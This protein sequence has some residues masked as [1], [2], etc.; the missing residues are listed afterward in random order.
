M[1]HPSRVPI[2]MPFLDFGPSP[3]QLADLIC[4]SYD[5]PDFAQR[6]I[7][8]F[9]GNSN[10]HVERAV[11][12]WATVGALTSGERLGDLR[13]R[14]IRGNC[15][16]TVRRLIGITQ[17]EQE[18][19]AMHAVRRVRKGVKY[20]FIGDAR[21][22]VILLARLWHMPRL[23]RFIERALPDKWFKEDFCSEGGI[24]DLVSA[25]C[26]AK[27]KW[28]PGM[29]DPNNWSPADV[30]RSPSFKTIAVWD[31]KTMRWQNG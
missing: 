5:D 28:F 13:D 25:G 1:G 18:L 27:L 8:I 22:G 2:L 15:R 31:G 19:A 16:L 4:V 30:Y 9:E 10:E 6:E 23:A 26:R 29:E 11:G 20:S 14:M 12:E 17:G 21:L 3:L 7:A 24:Q